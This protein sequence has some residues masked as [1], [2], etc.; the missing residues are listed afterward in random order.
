MVGCRQ[1]SFSAAILANE[2]AP[3]FRVAY[4]VVRR[5][6]SVPWG[7]FAR[8]QAACRLHRLQVFATTVAAVVF[9]LVNMDYG[10][11]RPTALLERVRLVLE[12]TNQT[13]R[14]WRFCLWTCQQSLF[15]CS[16]TGFSRQ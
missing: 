4:R 13:T 9:M 10:V 12:T 15:C 5:R 1:G 7:A 3:F 16:H 6:K 14:E 8:A 2:R 11:G